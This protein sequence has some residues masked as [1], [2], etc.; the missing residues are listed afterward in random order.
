MPSLTTSLV[1]ISFFLRGVDGP[2]SLFLAPADDRTT[3]PEGRVTPAEV[4]VTPA[5]GRVTAA[6]DRVTAA[7]GRVTTAGD[8]DIPA[9]D[10]VTA[11]RGLGFALEEVRWEL[12]GAFFLLPLLKNSD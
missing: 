6:E 1:D 2:L 3:F 7:D 8:R 4:R 11:E 10:C 12:P 5:E 9:E